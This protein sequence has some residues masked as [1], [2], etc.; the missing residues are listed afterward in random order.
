M[1]TGEC[2]GVHHLKVDSL[3]KLELYFLFG[4]T[5]RGLWPT[6]GLEFQAKS[7]V[8][9]VKTFCLDPIICLY[10]IRKRSIE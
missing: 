10:A 4:V 2:K 3:L 8:P 1:C 5:P 6:L 7:S 9:N